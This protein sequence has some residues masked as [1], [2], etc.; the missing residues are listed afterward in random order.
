VADHDVPSG[1]LG[2]KNSLDDI[3]EQPPFNALVRESLH[4]LFTGTAGPE[5]GPGTLA[6]LR[7]PEPAGSP[8]IQTAL[9]IAAQAPSF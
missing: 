9:G 7:S 5:P 6:R 4:H 8:G 2:F 3:A 1:D